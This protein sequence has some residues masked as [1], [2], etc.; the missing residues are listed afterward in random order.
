M[1]LAL[2]LCIWPLGKRWPCV[3]PCVGPGA[4]WAWAGIGAGAHWTWACH[5]RWR[6]QDLRPGLGR[7]SAL[8]PTGTVAPTGLR[9]ASALAPT[10]LKAWT[11]AGL[12]V[13]THG[14]PL[15]LRGPCLKSLAGPQRDRAEERRV[16]KGSWAGG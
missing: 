6:P 2:V 9:R 15:N 8:A 1:V 4:H 5:R 10:G 12:G 16:G 13:G 11:C 3:G 14:H 7:A